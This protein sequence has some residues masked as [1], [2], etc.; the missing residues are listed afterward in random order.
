MCSAAAR[1]ALAITALAFAS[2]GHGQECD[3][4][5]ADNPFFFDPEFQPPPPKKPHVNVI[6]VR[7]SAPGPDIAQSETSEVLPRP[8]RHEERIAAMLARPTKMDIR[9]MPLCDVVASLRD[10]APEVNFHVDQRAWEILRLTRNDS[11]TLTVDDVPLRSALA[12]V[13]R[14]H[15]LVAMVRHD[16]LV[17]THEDE[18]EYST[19]H[20]RVYPV[21]DLV[22]SQQQ[23]SFFALVD[24]IKT[25]VN[26]ESWDDKGGPGT[27]AVVPAA[28]CLVIWQSPN[29]HDEVL[30]LLR[31]LRAA[32]ELR[33]GE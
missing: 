1:M 6:V 12:I 19:M 33:R 13:L 20:R 32:Q 8:S 26:R 21:G 18:A 25:T 22:Q 30:K 3:D 23:D 9:D 14:P 24:A 7:P 10:A 17:I 2:L 5:F 27:I 31:A 29:N 4:P 15:G 16:A 11:M 28:G